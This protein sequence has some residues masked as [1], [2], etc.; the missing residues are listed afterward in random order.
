MLPPPP[1]GN[2]TLTTTVITT[3]ITII[4]NIEFRPWGPVIALERGV[5]NGDG[6]YNPQWRGIIYSYVTPLH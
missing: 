3:V 5:N 4:V 1:Q 2:L 6:V